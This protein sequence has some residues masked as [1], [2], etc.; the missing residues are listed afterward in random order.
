MWCSLHMVLTS[1]KQFAEYLLITVQPVNY[2]TIVQVRYCLTAQLHCPPIIV[3]MQMNLLVPA[4]NCFYSVE[5]SVPVD[6]STSTSNSTPCS[7]QSTCKT[8]H[9]FINLIEQPRQLG[10]TKGTFDNHNLPVGTTTR[11]NGSEC[12]LT[13]MAA[14]HPRWQ[15]LGS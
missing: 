3:C 9:V 4:R 10:V 15:P 11:Q 5:R 8:E 7:S 13:P 1:G 14:A 2:S 6:P 12:C